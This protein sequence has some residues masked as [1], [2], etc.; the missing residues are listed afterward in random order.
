[1]VMVS[2]PERAGWPRARFRSSMAHGPRPAAVRN[3]GN[4]EYGLYAGLSAH[5][6]GDALG[7]R[8]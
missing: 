5:A 8:L 1:M 3:K 4:P 6:P 2:A 7:R